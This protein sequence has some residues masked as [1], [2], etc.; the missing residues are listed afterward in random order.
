MLYSKALTLKHLRALAAIVDAGSVTAAAGKLHVTPPAV[1]TQLRGLED[2]VGAQVLLRGPDGKIALTPIGA[3]L[4]ATVRKIE[5]ALD[6][7]YQRVTAMRTGLAGYVSVGVVSTGKYFAP[8]LVARMKRIRPEIEVGLKVGNREDTIEWLTRGE[9]ELAI[10]GSP[11]Q[12][13]SSD[14]DELGD[15]PYVVIAPP[16]H[17]LAGQAKVSSGELLGETFL[18]RENGSGSRVLMTRYL[19]RIGEGRPYRSIEMGTNETIK[20]VVIAGLGVAIISA[21]TIV[22]ELEAGRLVTLPLEGLPIIRKW[23]LIRLNDVAI[24]PVAAAFRKF[25]LELKG[26]YLPSLPGK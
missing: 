8:G 2:I 13:P 5:N 7:S 12:A 4:F 9:I 6:L 22:P 11:P 26:D 21:H 17:R 18:C 3:E 1:S 10:M 15:H 24:S 16:E 19:D 23:Y 25:L 20:Q 14:F